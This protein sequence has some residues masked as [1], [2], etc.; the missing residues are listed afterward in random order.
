MVKRVS[1]LLLGLGL[2]GLGVL[3]LVSPS[4]SGASLAAGYWPLFL[5]LAGAVRVAGYLIDRHPKSPVGGLTLA[6]VGII[7]FCANRLGHN[8]ILLALSKYWFWF[9]LAFI[10]G[11]LMKQYLYRPADGGRA[12]RAFSP[13]AIL[14]MFVI[15]S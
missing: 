1:A 6:T 15:A 14:G 7:I 12:P 3:L 8:S 4:G 11:R 9:L 10:A 2:A 13:A 5:A